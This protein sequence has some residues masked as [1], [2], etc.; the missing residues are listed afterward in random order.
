MITAR[1]LHR[2]GTF[3]S[4]LIPLA[5]APDQVRDR[6]PYVRASFHRLHS[7][8]RWTAEQAASVISSLTGRSAYS[9]DVQFAGRTEHTTDASITR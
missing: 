8:R 1:A 3:L 2:L 5:G 7:V 4:A 6:V 9:L